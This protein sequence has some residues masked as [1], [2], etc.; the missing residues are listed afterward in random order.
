MKNRYTKRSKKAT[1]SPPFSM[2]WNIIPLIYSFIL[3]DFFL[4]IS[5]Y[6]EIFEGKKKKRASLYI[7]LVFWV[8]ASFSHFVFTDKLR[9]TPHSTSSRILHY[10]L[11]RR[12]ARTQQSEYS[13]ALRSTTLHSPSFNT[14]I[15]RELLLCFIVVVFDGRVGHV[16]LCDPGAQLI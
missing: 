16:L 5:Y 6:V 15:G 12:A 8:F 11:C 1:S 3:R 7:H 4:G 9:L 10:A 2:V 14:L 13:A